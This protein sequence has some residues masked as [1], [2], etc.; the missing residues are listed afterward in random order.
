MIHGILGR[1]IH[2]IEFQI[3]RYMWYKK[4]GPPGVVFNFY[5]H[6]YFGTSH[7]FAV[8]SFT[9][10]I[11]FRGFVMLKNSVNPSTTASTFIFTNGILSYESSLMMATSAK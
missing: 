6:W 11:Y 8:Q 7:P 4:S 2:K 10:N 1:V 9:T 3:T 5:I